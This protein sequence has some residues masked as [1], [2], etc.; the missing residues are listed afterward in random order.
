MKCRVFLFGEAEKGQ[1]C[2]PH[3]LQSLPQLLDTFGNPPE[4]SLGI[5]NAIQMLLSKN[6]LIFFRI[7]EEGYSKE[8]YFRGIKYLQDRGKKLKLS[9]IYLPGVGDKEIID[10]L[11]HLCRNNKTLLVLSESDLFDYLTLSKY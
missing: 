7:Q 4:E 5:P 2:I 8:D 3:S 1:L 9:A 11:M 6:K 10:P